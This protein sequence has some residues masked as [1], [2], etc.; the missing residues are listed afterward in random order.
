V[1][2]S[3]SASLQVGSA[4]VLLDTPVRLVPAANLDLCHEVCFRCPLGVFQLRVG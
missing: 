3:V 1:V 2:T 4:L